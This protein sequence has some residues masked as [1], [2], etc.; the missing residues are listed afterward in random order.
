LRRA[1]LRRPGREPARAGRLGER[2]ALA[3][4]PVRDQRLRAVRSHGAEE[5][6][7]SVLLFLAATLR[8]SV[9]YALAATGA[10]AG[11]RGGVV[12]L[13][14]EGFMLNAALG[15]GLGPWSLPTPGLG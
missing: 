5:E 12:C 7:V 11:E 13:G 15:Y 14:L 3:G 6:L 1:R 8:I 9:P 10:S 2:A 4:D